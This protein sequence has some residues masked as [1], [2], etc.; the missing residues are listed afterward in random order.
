[1][2]RACFERIIRLDPSA[3][4]AYIGIAIVYDKEENF[5][6]YFDF[7]SKAYRINRRHPLVLLHLA[8]HYLFRKELHKCM[9]FCQEGLS[10]L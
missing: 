6:Q 9:K 10:S 8:E 7:I 4:E 2:A 5:K 3:V 1:M